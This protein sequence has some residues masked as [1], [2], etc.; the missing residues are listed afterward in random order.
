MLDG[1]SAANNTVQGNLIGTRAS[2][3]AGLGNGRAGIGIGGAPGNTIGGT[4]TGA[5]NVLSANGDAGI[6]LI[7]SGATGNLI[8][9]NTIGA[10]LTGTSRLGNTAQGIYVERAGSNVIGGTLSGAGNLISANN[11]QGILL[12]NTS[13]NLIQGNLIGTKA[14]G[15]SDLGNVFHGVDLQVGANNNTIGGGAG[16]GNRIAFSQPINAGVR[17]RDGSTNNAILGNAIFANATL[18]IDLGGYGPN[19]NSPCGAGT[20]ANMAQ[21]YPMLTQAVS[22]NGTVVRG[23]LNSRRNQTFLL[24][25]F[26]NPSCGSTRFPNNGQGQ[27]YLGQT[28]VVTSS[29]CNTSFVVNLAAQV[30]G[31]YVI[32]ATATDSAN[33]T[34]EFSACI[35]VVSA[36]TLAV[37]LAGSQVSLAWTNTPSGF[38]LKQTASLAPP[39]QWTTVT[40]SPVPS[41]GWWVVTV[42]ADAAKR[43]YVLR[44]E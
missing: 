28:S 12:T 17:V 24:Q 6:Y 41:N 20:G 22:G 30:P 5:G 33:N 15:I 3:T 25:F 37:S 4:T 13:G 9:G 11:V 34:S 18:G 31:G 1:A 27:F 29:D 7:A 8:Q 36:P 21:N 26:A 14:D 2:G 44:L 43:F 35:P 39:V 10:D 23:T 40:N 42:P 38:V 32:T 19:T 16:A